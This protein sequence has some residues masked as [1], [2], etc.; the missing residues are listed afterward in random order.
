MNPNVLYANSERPIHIAAS[1]G[2][3]ELVIDLV[4]KGAYMWVFNAHGQSPM[5]VAHSCGHRNVVRYLQKKTTS[6][7][8]RKY[9]EFHD[10]PQLVKRIINQNGTLSYFW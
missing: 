2:I 3:L 10:I 6:D 1:T 8:H 5:D 9:A 4:E 7:T